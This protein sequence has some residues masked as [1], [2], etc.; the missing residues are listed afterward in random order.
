ME[1]YENELLRAAKADLAM[2]QSSNAELST[3]KK[4][5]SFLA[6]AGEK[7]SR[8]TGE[9]FREHIPEDICGVSSDELA[10]S[11]N[12]SENELMA[13]LT[14]GISFGGRTQKAVAKFPKM[15]LS[16]VQKRIKREKARLEQL[17]AKFGCIWYSELYDLCYSRA[18]DYQ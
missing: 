17:K 10:S 11:M 16:E 14:S 7:K 2:D 9:L 8:K 6:I 1:E 5:R 4:M 18:Y 3:F 12:L 15:M 13:Q